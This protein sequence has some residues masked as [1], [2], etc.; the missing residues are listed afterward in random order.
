MIVGAI[1]TVVDGRSLSRDTSR[2]VMEAILTGQVS[3]AQ[4]GALVTGLR[5]K[6]ESADEIAG[7]L[8]SMRA[9]ATRVDLGDLPAV[10]ACG[11]GGRGVSWFNVT[12]TAALI[13]TG[14]G[15]KV[16][17]HGNRSFTRKSGSA[18]AARSPR[19]S[20]SPSGR[21]SWPSACARPGSGSCSPRPFTPA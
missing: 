5:M 4:F 21:R 1:Q 19:R 2:E 9:H 15:A 16:A 8:Q 7:F 17:K 10:D 20:D 6:G 13:A 18:D 14:A 11:T 12:T 3:P